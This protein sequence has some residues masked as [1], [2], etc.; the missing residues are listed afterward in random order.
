MPQ[1]RKACEN[2]RC[3]HPETSCSRAVTPRIPHLSRRSFAP[4]RSGHSGTTLAPLTVDKPKQP[5]PP[6]GSPSP[7]APSAA[8]ARRVAA[9]P[10]NFLTATFRPR[11]QFVATREILFRQCPRLSASSAR[12]SPPIAEGASNSRPAR[13]P[14][15]TVFDNYARRCATVDP[16]LLTH[17]SADRPNQRTRAAS[18]RLAPNLKIPMPFVAGS[19]LPASIERSRL[20][21]FAQ[22]MHRRNDNAQTSDLYTWTQFQAGSGY[23]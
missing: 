8:K 11:P 1:A 3:S 16:T 14:V 19:S 4:L 17:S 18:T 6:N 5:A 10:T 7:T 12:T 23:A 13:A 21:R 9:P 15:Q 2:L 20:R 22:S